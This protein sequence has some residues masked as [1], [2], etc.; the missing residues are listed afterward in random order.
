M[1]WIKTLTA[2]TRES[3]R[4]RSVSPRPPIIGV[5]CL[6]IALIIPYLVVSIVFHPAGPTISS[7]FSDERGTVTIL[8]AVLLAAGAAWAFSAYLLAPWRER[9]YRVFWLITAAAIAFLAID[10]LFG[11]HEGIGDKLYEHTALSALVDH[12]PLRNLNDAIVILYGVVALPMAI[13][14]LPGLVRVPRVLGL[15]IIAFAWYALHTVIDSISEPPTD[16]SIIME[17]SAKVMCA[18]F[19]A[20]AMLTGLRGVV[21]LRPRLD[22]SRASDL[23]AAV[24]N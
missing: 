1:N 21:V 14:M 2:N 8:S 9:R 17:E 18:C 11:L 7:D 13:M 22:A 23:E 12:T 19:I 24:V 20:L 15:L 5:M 10:E 3:W 16:L 6:F 4:A